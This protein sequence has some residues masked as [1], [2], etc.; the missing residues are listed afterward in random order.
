MTPLYVPVLGSVQRRHAEADQ[1]LAGL[2]ILRG[3]TVTAPTHRASLWDTVNALKLGYD[4]GGTP[5][6]T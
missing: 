6:E 3:A 2:G 1:Q 4:G 5:L